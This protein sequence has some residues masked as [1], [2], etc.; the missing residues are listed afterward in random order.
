MYHGY[1]DVPT[2]AYFDFGN[3]WTGSLLNDFNYRIVPKAKDE[4][5]VLKVYIWYGVVCF[6]L[7]ETVDEFEEEFS[8]EG[9]ERVIDKLNKL[10]GEYREKV[11]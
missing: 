10:I 3:T 9:Y 4:P 8:A 1:I 2:F 5:P 11:K 7:A 6:D